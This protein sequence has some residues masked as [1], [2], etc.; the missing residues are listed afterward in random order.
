MKPL[1]I[2]LP[3]LLACSACAAPPQIPV[4]GS[5][6]GAA[7][8]VAAEAEAV[9]S[10]EATAAT[11]PLSRDGD[12]VLEIGQVL[13]IA[14][15]GNASTGFIWEFLSEGAPQLRRFVPVATAAKTPVADDGK[16]PMVGSPS[17]YRWYFEAVQPGATEIRMVYH[18]PWEKDTTQ[19]GESVFRIV[20]RE[21]GTSP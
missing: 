5:A 19:K 17:V 8:T 15:Q 6:R 21:A 9:L 13:E 7:E 10:T 11:V 3:L 12:T 1:A 20:V 2:A 18:R 14:L 16:P 4:A